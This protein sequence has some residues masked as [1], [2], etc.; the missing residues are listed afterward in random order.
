MLLVITACQRRQPCT[1]SPWVTSD[2]G[3]IATILLSLQREG[4]WEVKMPFFCLWWSLCAPRQS[5][6]TGVGPHGFGSVW[7]RTNGVIYYST[8]LL[9]SDKGSLRPS[10]LASTEHIFNMNCKRNNKNM[11]W[12]ISE[13]FHKG[14]AWWQVSW[15]VLP[16]ANFQVGWN[17]TPWIQHS[18]LGWGQGGSRKKRNR[19]KIF[20]IP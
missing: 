7:R 13:P 14:P 12:L 20:R 3:D 8:E 10:R 19:A 11:K 4:S 6:V 15:S 2:T 9:L 1:P 17:Q 16:F 5:M 18:E